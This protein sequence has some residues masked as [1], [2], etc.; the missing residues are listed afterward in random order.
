[1]FVADEHRVGV[2]FGAA[3]A[4]LADLVHGDALITSSADCYE[5]GMT[6]L[7]QAD[8]LGSA[9]G[10][11]KLVEAQFG[12]LV[13]RADSARLPLRWHATGPEGVLFPVLD[14]DL[15]LTALSE[16]ATMLRLAGAYR[17]P[18]GK[19]GGMLDRAVLQRV[20]AATIH[21]FIRRV[22]DAIVHPAGAPAPGQEGSDPSP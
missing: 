11:S 17:P 2:G 9:P 5:Q 16:D 1:M 13:T 14:A 15:E 4:R 22:A 21:M 19:A 8:P 3:Q 18:P 20:A 6:G 7:A 10:V 12:Q